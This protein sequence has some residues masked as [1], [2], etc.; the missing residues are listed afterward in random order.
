M[1]RACVSGVGAAG[2]SVR[3][4]RARASASP[5]PLLERLSPEPVPA[6]ASE[7][8]RAA[9]WRRADVWPPAEVGCAH[10]RRGTLVNW[11]ILILSVCGL[12]LGSIPYCFGDPGAPHPLTSHHGIV[13]ARTT[14]SA[15]ADRGFPPVA[16]TCKSVPCN[17][18]QALQPAES[19]HQPRGLGGDASSARSAP[20]V[21][22]D[23]A[24]A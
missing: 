13:N 3:S 16:A 12:C 19:V 5:L 22:R 4:V 11:I 6:R 14:V 17:R 21:H 9:R 23:K 24:K 7:P 8:G 2:G 1:R 15:R 20:R 18:A 10:C